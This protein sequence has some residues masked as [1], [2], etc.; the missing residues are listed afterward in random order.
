MNR[1]PTLERTFL[2]K[3]VGGWAEKTSD[4]TRQISG[5]H[6]SNATD[7]SGG[8]PNAMPKSTA[9]ARSLLAGTVS[10]R[11]KKKTVLSANQRFDRKKL[12]SPLTVDSSGT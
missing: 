5:A 12:F 8:C 4:L 10:K 1:N 3:G 11:G 6:A 7:V 2:G 9:H